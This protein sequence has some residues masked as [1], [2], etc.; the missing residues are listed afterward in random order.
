[1]SAP[2]SDRDA[3]LERRLTTS[4]QAHAATIL[5]APPYAL[6]DRALQPAHDPRRARYGLISA[7]LATAIV[8][9]G[10]TIRA[11]HHDASKTASEQL[12]CVRSVPNDFAAVVA[13]GRIPGATGTVVERSIGRHPAARGTTQPK[14][15][16]GRSKRATDKHLDGGRRRSSHDRSS[17]GDQRLRG[18]VRGRSA[19]RHSYDDRGVSA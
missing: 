11:E 2:R 4:L 5:A 8:L 19:T 13:A 3:E 7:T 1:M 14:S 6:P 17:G 15:G 18:R 9:A 10:I 16:S 12:Q